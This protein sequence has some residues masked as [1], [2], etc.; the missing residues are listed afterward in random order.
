[1]NKVVFLFL[2][3]WTFGLYGQGLHSNQLNHSLESKIDSIVHLG[4]KQKAFPGA[5]VLIFKC[6]SIRI[7]KSYGFHTYDSIIRVK[8]HHLYDLASVTKI[9]ASTLAFMKLYEIFNINLEFRA[10]NLM[11]KVNTHTHTPCRPLERRHARP[12]ALAG[13]RSH[14]L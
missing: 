10:L 5:Q 9:L 2:L 11:S 13:L 8:N 3:V 4:I 14:N 6:D 7:N 12:V 1:M